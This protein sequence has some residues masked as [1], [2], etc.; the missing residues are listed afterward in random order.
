MRTHRVK[1]N[2]DV[3]D[4]CSAPAVQHLLISYLKSGGT[5]KSWYFAYA[6]EYY[7]FESPSR[8]PFVII[9][10]C[11]ICSGQ[12]NVGGQGKWVSRNE[13]LVYGMFQT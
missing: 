3:C 10:S 2:L 9:N 11:N 5:K 13:A 8:P 6:E 1:L 4:R 7:Y 12:K